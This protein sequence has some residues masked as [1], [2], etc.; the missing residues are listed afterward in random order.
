MDKDL[1]IKFLE[2]YDFINREIKQERKKGKKHHDKEH[3]CRDHH[4]K[5]H[6]DKEHHDKKHKERLSLTAINT[7]R[8]LIDSEN[9]NQRTLSKKLNVTAQ[10]MSETIKK[11]FENGYVEKINNKVNN[12]NIISLTEKGKERAIH[13]DKVIN[14]VTEGIFAN[15]EQ[16]EKATL[17]NLLAK[18]SVED[19]NEPT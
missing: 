12:E 1:L 14:N 18:I 16:D 7:L 13:F 6:H 5:E 4:D 15:L 10:A 8:L 11:L 9:I 2:V 17:L 19:E 3:K